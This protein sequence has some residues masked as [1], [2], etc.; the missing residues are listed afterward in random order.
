MGTT[1]LGMT[2]IVANQR[3]MKYVPSV[4]GTYCRP[5]R[6]P[7]SR[8]ASVSWKLL[9]KYFSF[10]SVPTAGAMISPGGSD[11]P[12]WM[13]T[14]PIESTMIFLSVLIGSGASTGAPM[15]TGSNPP[16][17]LSSACHETSVLSSFWPWRS[18]R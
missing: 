18:S 4:S 7:A 12:S 10:R 15:T 5:L 2:S 9:W 16:T 3:L 14:M 13:V 1:V 11:G 17:A 8:N 6:P